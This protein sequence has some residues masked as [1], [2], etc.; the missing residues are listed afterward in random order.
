VASVSDFGAYVQ[1]E[2]GVAADVLNLGASSQIEEAPSHDER[3][4]GGS[5]GG[6]VVNP[7]LTVEEGGVAPEVA[8]VVTPIAVVPSQKSLEMDGSGGVGSHLLTEDDVVMDCEDSVAK[9]SSGPQTR[10]QG[11]VSADPLTGS[12]VASVSDSGAYVQQEDGVAAD[13]SQIEEAPSHERPAGGS[14]GGGVVNPLL[15]VEEGGVTPEVASVVTPIAVVP[16]LKPL[17]M[18]ISEG[19]DVNA[20]L[21]ELTDDVASVTL[22]AVAAVANQKRPAAGSTGVGNP[23]PTEVARDV[24]CEDAVKPPA[25]GS[26]GGGVVGT[27]N[28]VSQPEML[29]GATTASAVSGLRAPVV[30]PRTAGA[31][32]KTSRPPAATAVFTSAVVPSAVSGLRAPAVV[33]PRTA[34][35][36]VKTSRPPAATAVFTS[37]VVPSA[38]KG[39][40][41]PAVVVPRTAGAGVKTSRPPAATAVFTSAVVPSAVSGLRAPVVVPRTAGAGVKTSRPLVGNKKAFSFL[42][43]MSDMQ[44]EKQHASSAI[45]KLK[46]FRPRPQFSDDEEEDIRPVPNVVDSVGAL[47]VSV[48]LKQK[49]K[50]VLRYEY[51]LAL[52]FVKERKCDQFPSV[53]VGTNTDGR[54]LYSP[55]KSDGSVFELSHVRGNAVSLLVFG[56]HVVVL[57]SAENVCRCIESKAGKVDLHAGDTFTLDVIPGLLHR[58]ETFQYVA[59]EN[60]LPQHLKNV[61]PGDPILASIDDNLRELPNPPRV[62]SGLLLDLLSADST[63]TLVTSGFSRS[64]GASKVA[65]PKKRVACLSDY[66]HKIGVVPRGNILDCVESKVMKTFGYDACGSFGS[67]EQ[68]KDG[69]Q[70]IVLVTSDKVQRY[71]GDGL[72]DLVRKKSGV[73]IR[74]AYTKDENPQFTITTRGDLAQVKRASGL[75]EEVVLHGPRRLEAMTDALICETEVEMMDE[76]YERTAFDWCGPNKSVRLV[77]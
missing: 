66:S 53:F 50:V 62:G 75:I 58:G 13:S 45:V 51:Y 26:S 2:D 35:A 56:D 25:A 67:I 27:I 32:V 61:E 38:V 6:G 5:S 71:L 10:R 44:S 19:D 69:A 18:D 40:R 23:V 3:P 41:A 55:T 76:G 33:V 59:G 12:S 14:S 46:S 11:S 20:N 72:L 49:T 52:I 1:Q 4:A 37:A 17:E 29:V 60:D 64:C 36:G 22:V 68:F 54:I 21:P 7:V 65:P 74:S 47:V 15:T 43:V 77:A 16:S 31:G 73:E 39:L 9:G 8:S 28:S 48:L 34:G 70:Q 63:A 30:V 57:K 24:V 42:E